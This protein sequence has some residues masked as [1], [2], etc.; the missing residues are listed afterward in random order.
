[1]KENFVKR[2][3]SF[4]KGVFM[5]F[6]L[7]L[8][9]GLFAV[10]SFAA[11]VEGLIYNDETKEV[12]VSISYTGGNEEHNFSIHWGICTVRSDLTSFI[13]GRLIDSGWRDTGKEEFQT[14]LAVPANTI[15]CPGSTVSVLGNGF[16]KASIQLP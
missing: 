16:S 15:P 9:V 1:M 13:D 5:K 10:Q 2:N 11:R 4:D 8:V 14:S 7:M 3:L 6:A 12:V